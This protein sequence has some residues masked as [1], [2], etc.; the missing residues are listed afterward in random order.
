MKNVTGGGLPAETWKQFM[1]AAHHGVPP[2]RLPLGGALPPVVIE[3]DGA[4]VGDPVAGLMRDL[5]P[6]PVSRDATGATDGMS[7]TPPADIGADPPNMAKVIGI[8]LGTTNSCVAVMDGKDARVIENAKARAPP[9]R[10]WPSATMA[11]V[12]SA[13]PPSARRSPTRK[14]RFLRSSA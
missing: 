11:N 13:S 6:V 2:A 1:Q 10:W 4:Q 12:W 7:L 3:G 14:T 8:D 9:R 5:A